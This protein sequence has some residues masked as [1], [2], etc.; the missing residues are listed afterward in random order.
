MNID[1]KNIKINNIYNSFV[2]GNQIF[3]PILCADGWYD[4]TNGHWH[5][6]DLKKDN[7][8]LYSFNIINNQ[9]ENKEKFDRIGIHINHIDDLF[10][11]YKNLIDYFI[12]SSKERNRNSIKEGKIIDNNV[13]S[14]Y[15]YI[16]G[17]GGIINLSTKDMIKIYGINQY[18]SNDFYQAG[19]I[20]Q[21]VQFNINKLKE[22]QNKQKEI[23]LKIKLNR[24]IEKIL[25]F[26]N[27]IDYK[28]DMNKGEIEFKKFNEESDFYEID[29][30]TGELYKK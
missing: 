10:I 27:Y 14:D 3:G 1:L 28:I 21:R 6:L 12:F 30:Q 20:L 7:K 22:K 25:V 8:S 5:K 17:D 11:K 2:K 24:N 23:N 15:K 29:E 18:K 26:S 9:I 16:P 13:Y 19:Y 4:F